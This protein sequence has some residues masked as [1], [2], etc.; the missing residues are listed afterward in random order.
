MTSVFEGK[1]L[2]VGS[3]LNNEKTIA[4]FISFKN[5]KDKFI[6]FIM[7]L[8]FIIQIILFNYL[9]LWGWTM[10]F[11]NYKPSVSILKSKF[12]GLE[13]FQQI[14]TGGSTFFIVLK[15]TLIFNGLNIAATIVP[16]IL[17]IFL[18]EIWNSNVRKV[19]QT[20]ISLPYYISWIIVYG[21]FFLFMSNEGIINNSLA[22]VGLIENPINFLQNEE[23]VYLVQTLITVWKSAGWSAIIYISAISALDQEVY[24]AGR[25]DGANKFQRMWYITIPG[26]IPTFI[27]LLILNVGN[28]LS[29]FDQYFMFYNPMTSEHI[30]VIDTYAYRKGLG[31]GDYSYATAVGIFKTGISVLL[32]T[33]CNKIAKIYTGKS[34]I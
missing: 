20:V 29:A 8:P 24:E 2:E 5:R 18:T 4:G 13:N 26:I 9:P 17:A 19:V 15:N 22:N 23:T 21:I 1:G 10:A 27:V 7:T 16:V 11:V 30:E 14:F 28:I 12:I 32:L 3:L 6:L 31:V 34:V 25:V 33:I